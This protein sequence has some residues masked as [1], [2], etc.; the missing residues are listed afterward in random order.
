MAG[1][2]QANAYRVSQWVS[3]KPGSDDTF[4]VKLVGHSHFLLMLSAGAVALGLLFPVVTP[5]FDTLFILYISLTIAV[6]MISLN[7]KS[8]LQVLAFPLMTAVVSAFS[9]SLHIACVKL[10]LTQGDAGYFISK[11]STLLDNQH[12][13]TTTLMV[14]TTVL[15]CFILVIKSTTYTL[16]KASAFIIDILA[17]EQINIKGNLTAGLI[18][19]EQAAQLKHNLYQHRGFFIAILGVNRL[20]LC[21]IVT[22]MVILLISLTAGL[23]AD[24]AESVSTGHYYLSMV[25]AITISIQVTSATIAVSCQYLIN[26][27]SNAFVEENQ[28]SEEKFS[29]TI[30]VASRKAANISI[31]MEYEQARKIADAKT[32]NNV[33]PE[34]NHPQNTITD[35]LEWFDQKQHLLKSLW[36]WSKTAKS[37]YYEFI[38]NTLIENSSVKTVLMAASDINQ[39]GVT[40]PVNTAIQLV[41]QKMKVLLVDLDNDRNAVNKVFEIKAK[42]TKPVKTT[43]KNLSVLPSSQDHT[44]DEINKSISRIKSDYDRIIIYAPNINKIQNPTKVTHLL[45]AAMIFGNE[46]T[47]NNPVMNQLYKTLNRQSQLILEPGH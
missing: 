20:M 9:L 42:D 43:I 8:A 13:Y 37:R 39:I 35:E 23:I 29:E 11:I 5:F 25:L 22:Q 32:T 26:N 14:L 46:K 4:T 34:S 31:E 6:V 40:V 27:L 19:A 36:K 10:I 30:S 45:G 2:F 38:A 47:I 21:L 16:K 1:F 24:A 15:I 18:N 3:L 44:I 7:A 12:V 33:K 41:K 17:T 28:I